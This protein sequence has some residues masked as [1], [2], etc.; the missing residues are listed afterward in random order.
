[1][2]VLP[3]TKLA[4]RPTST[5]DPR[6]TVVRDVLSLDIEVPLRHF[7][8]EAA[9]EIAVETLALVGPS[10][11]GKTTVLRAVAGLMKPSRGEVRLGNHVWFSAREGIDLSPDLRSI[12]LV[13]QDYALFPHMTVRQNIEYGGKGRSGELMERF[14]ISHLASAKPGQ[15]SGGERQR[16]ALART[17]AREPG[18]LLLDEPLSALDAHTKQTVRSEL[19]ELLVQAALPTLIV[20]HDFEDAASLADRVGVIVDG[21]LRQNAR[22]EDLVA[23]PADQ[24][25]A[26]LTGANVLTGHASPAPDGLTAVTL[27]GGTQIYSTDEAT[28]PVSVA[29]Y[30]WEV[31]ISRAEPDESAL[32]HLRGVVR[33]VVTIGNRV[34]VRVGPLTAEIT[35]QSAGRLGVAEGEL[36]VASFKATATRLIAQSHR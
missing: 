4:T 21:R 35:Q 28:G 23:A 10:G 8:L 12:G 11:A 1:V 7:V 13:F 33:S 19:H 2:D 15:L 32:N 26:H 3:D 14:R 24:F 34:R 9:L 18:V 36:L 20:T 5:Q 27:E 25:V 16:V 31:S 29:I 6:E 17:I 30:P 22:P